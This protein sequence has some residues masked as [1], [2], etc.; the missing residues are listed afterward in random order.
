MTT[1]AVA[2]RAGIQAP[3]IYRLFGDKD[4]LIEAVAESVMDS[5]VSEKQVAPAGGVS[6]VEALHAAWQRHV[7][8]G[9]GNPEL[10]AMIAAPGRGDPSP[11]TLAGIEVLR[12]LISAMAAAGHLIVSE[13]RAL[14]M[15]HSA[16]NG[17]VIALLEEDSSTRD[18]GLTDAV[19]N[20]I[21]T[22]IIGSSRSETT[23]ATYTLASA[24]QFGTV[25][26]DLPALSA[27]ERELLAEW[28]GRSVTSMENAAA[29][30]PDA[31][32]LH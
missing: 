21:L 2:E 27:A 18:L 6:P 32:R 5:Y 3:T 16:G 31:A 12:G 17:A 7:D 26:H 4:G 13:R 8:F 29:T 9:L 1:R 22:A 19:C 30:L 23:I 20:A 15:V 11:A 28:I 25:I 24:V 14:Q 10:Y